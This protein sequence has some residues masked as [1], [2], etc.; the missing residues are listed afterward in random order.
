MANLDHCDSQAHKTKKAS[1]KDPPPG[2]PSSAPTTNTLPRIL[3]RHQIPP[4]VL[5]HIKRPQQGIAAGLHF[6][7][8]LTN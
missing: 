2:W 8:D 1:R 3:P 6:A 7:A 5:G 4:L